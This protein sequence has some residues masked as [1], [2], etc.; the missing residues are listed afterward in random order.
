MY[1]KLLD[2]L[3]KW[4]LIS[5]IVL[6][7][8]GL[9]LAGTFFYNRQVKDLYETN[10]NQLASVA[11]LK[12]S[13]ISQWRRERIGDLRVNSESS[14]FRDAIVQL[15]Q[16]QDDPELRNRI[17]ERLILVRDLYD[18]QNVMIA[19]PDGKLFFSLDSSLAELEPEATQLVKDVITTNQLVFGDFFR[20]KGKNKVY[21]DLAGPVFDDQN[22]LAAI[23]ILRVDPDTYLYPLI[24]TWPTPSQT[25]ETLLVKRSDVSVIFLNT[26]RHRADPPLTI[27]L[28]ISQADLPA[29]QAVLG[30]TGEVDG[31]DYRGVEV[32]AAV[33]PIPDTQWFII[34]KIDQSEIDNE[35]LLRRRFV[36]LLVILAILMTGS[37]GVLL[38]NNRQRILY[39]NLFQLEKERHIVLEETRTILYSIGDGVIATNALGLVTH[40]NPV[41]EKLTGWSEAEA[42]GC[43]LTEVFHIIN[44]T[45]RAVVENPVVHVLR[46]GVIVGLANHTLL[47]TRDGHEHPITDSGAPV[48]DE[49][50]HIQGVVLVFRDQTEERKTQQERSLL[51]NTIRAS[52]DEIYMFDPKSML[53]RFVNA[54]ALKNLGYSMEQLY[55]MTPLDIKPEV[56]AE[57]FHDMLRP[58]IDHQ[59]PIQVFQ[60]VHQ[61]A[62]GS[63]YP[64]EVHVQLFEQDGS[65]VFLAIVQDI[66]ERKKTEEDINN[67]NA[68]LEQRVIERTTQLEAS[69]KELEA[70]AYSVSHD[71]R[72]PLRGI[73]GWSQALLEDNLEQLDVPGQLYLTRV[74]KET[75]RMGRL[76][77]DLLELS[78]VTR[79]EMQ[80]G[81]VNLSSLANSIAERLKEAN[82]TRDIEFVIHSGLKARG[83]PQ[84]LEIALTNLLENA[85]K[86]TGTQKKAQVE[87]GCIHIDGKNT[88]FIKDNGVGFDMTYSS[89]LFGAFQRMHKQTEFPGTG[90]GLATVQ[91]IIIRHGGAIWADAK[92]DEGA[93]FYFT[94]EEIT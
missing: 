10:Y 82:K 71:L 94:L 72:A 35:I 51:A 43:P 55:A 37:L 74:R 93:T 59:I 57:S 24:Q 49:N 60:T 75:Q 25:A 65:S 54:G 5:P 31:R 48:L 15:T 45:T 21:I 66:T 44:E 1:N 26:L 16:K 6:L 58:L 92:P 53:F 34:S 61:R 50:G 90:I 14:L 40:F 68:E 4:I 83:D 20:V 36:A 78:R 41:A 88:F 77:D 76:I 11:K 29:A 38:F 3:P 89:N 84:L 52:M 73:D 27:K 30:K 62:D 87:F 46:D 22:H 8:L 67:L 81:E 86:F 32:V 28:P 39:Q 7:S 80:I 56:T 17:S 12:T 79:S 9:I 42:L 63:T 69:N 23:L 85:W 2:T 64:V 70:F 18:Y 47:V 33:L 19:L 91:R 13:E